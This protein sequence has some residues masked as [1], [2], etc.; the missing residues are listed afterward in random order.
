M[1]HDAFLGCDARV[2]LPRMTQ[3]A[4]WDKI[5]HHTSCPASFLVLSGLSRGSQLP[6]DTEPI[7]GR[8][9]TVAPTAPILVRADVPAGPML[10]ASRAVLDA[11]LLEAERNALELRLLMFADDPYVTTL[12]SDDPMTAGRGA[13]T[14]ELLDITTPTLWRLSGPLRVNDMR[15]AGSQ[16]T[17]SLHR[18]R[19]TVASS[20]VNP[21]VQSPCRAALARWTRGMRRDMPPRPGTC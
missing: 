20:S 10:D 6:A 15:L 8:Y 11:A 2:K 18:G 1:R 17:A 5:G 21:A 3:H 9:G 19:A 4:L 12:E 13:W 14:L 16:I 7:C